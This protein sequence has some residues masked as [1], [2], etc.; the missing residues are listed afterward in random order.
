M[1]SGKGTEAG[2]E[3]KTLSISR[4]RRR[5]DDQSSDTIVLGATHGCADSIRK[6]RPYAIGF[7]AGI[8]RRN[9]SPG[10]N[11]SGSAFEWLRAR[12]AAVITAVGQDT[13]LS[14]DSHLSILQKRHASGYFFE[15]LGQKLKPTPPCVLSYLTGT[16]LEGRWWRW[17][18]PPL[19]GSIKVGSG[20][21]DLRRT[22]PTRATK[23]P[24]R[25]WD[26]H[27]RCGCSERRR[28]G[29][30]GRWDSLGK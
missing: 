29:C 1:Y 12:H 9:N 10:C 18:P 24:H 13:L 5:S 3:D 14:L 15:S 22:I 4:R 21:D 30:G 20:T 27:R 23:I 11:Q 6:D 19:R 26:R 16:H 28:E 17:P 25:S 7:R 8:G 2:V